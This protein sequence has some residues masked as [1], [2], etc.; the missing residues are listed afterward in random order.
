M[1]QIGDEAVIDPDA[2]WKLAPPTTR[3][4]MVA[5]MQ[6][7]SY[8]QHYP[9]HVEDVAEVYLRCQRGIL[10]YE[11]LMWPI[12]SS[13]LARETCACPARHDTETQLSDC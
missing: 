11:E 2:Y 13:L 10:P 5:Y 12:S 8:R 1:V 4:K 3:P 7:K 9:K 6:S